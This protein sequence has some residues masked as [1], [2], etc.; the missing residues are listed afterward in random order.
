MGAQQQQ[1]N[2]YDSYAAGQH[3]IIKSEFMEVDEQ[4]EK[5]LSGY[6]NY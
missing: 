5:E 6:V 4:L 2:D 1:Q 3:A